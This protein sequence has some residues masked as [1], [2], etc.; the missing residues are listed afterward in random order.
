MTLQT[1]RKPLSLVRPVAEPEPAPVSSTRRA[2][3]EG[4]PDASLVERLLAGDTSVRER[5]YLR[6]VEYIAGM[7]ARILRSVDASEDVVQDT[8]VIAFQRIHT[9]RDPAAL[10]GWLAAIAISQVHRKLARDRLLRTFGFDGKLGDTPLDEL[11]VED[12]TAETR[13]ELAALDLVLREL[14]ARQR[15]AWMLRYV[16]GEPLEQVAAACRCSL[17]TVKR[18]IVLADTRVQ[19]YVRIA[20]DEEVSS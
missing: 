5:L 10:R 9:L 16:E 18:W 4:E 19:Q 7:S 2:P 8:F 11:A 12:T 1:A 15:I 13:S 6:H 17:A 3:G 20:R 14:P